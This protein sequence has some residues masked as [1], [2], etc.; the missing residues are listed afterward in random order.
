MKNSCGK[1]GG[2]GDFED[3]K[4]GKLIECECQF[5]RRIAASMPPYIRRAEVKSDHILH[6]V[7]GMVNRSI[8]IRSSW[9]DMKAFLKVVMFKYNQKFIRITSDLEIKNVFLGGSSR[10]AKGEDFSGDVF[11]NVQDLMQDPDLVIIELNKIGYANKAAAGNLREAIDIR[12]SKDKATWL[13]SDHSNP[14]TESSVAFS[15]HVWDYIIEYFKIIDIPRMIHV[16]SS[17]VSPFAEV[18]SPKEKPSK[19]S[20]IPEIVPLKESNDSLDPE[21]IDNPV[22]SSLS[23]Y[24]RAYSG[25]RKTKGNF[26]TSSRLNKR[27]R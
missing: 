5:I 11:N 8:F 16:K 7:V 21:V 12:V 14:F 3:K 24:E 10:R 2:Q 18:S 23:V 22:S 4:T 1:C 27:N 6:P 15:N 13:F 26:K 19:E 9:Q 20:S 25:E 17:V